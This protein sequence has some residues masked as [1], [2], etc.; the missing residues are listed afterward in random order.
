ML[1]ITA[2][3]FMVLFSVAYSSNSADDELL[4]KVYCCVLN[5]LEADGK[6]TVLS[7]PEPRKLTSCKNIQETEPSST[8]GFYESITSSGEVVNLYCN[9]DTLCGGSGWTRVAYLDMSNSSHE[10]PSTMKENNL[11]VRN[12]R[13]G[14]TYGCDSVKIPTYDIQYSE[15]CGRVSGYQ[16]GSTNGFGYRDNRFKNI[17]SAYLDGVSITRGSPRQHVW[18]YVAGLNQ[19]GR[20][21]YPAH[22]CPKPDGT[23]GTEPS[24]SFVGNDFYCESGNSEPGT[25]RNGVPYVSDMLWDGKDCYPD[26]EV[27]C[28]DK[29]QGVSQPWFYKKFTSST[30]DD[31]ELRSCCNDEYQLD[32]EDI[33]LVSYELYIR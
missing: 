13:R 21:I 24:P 28:R 12:C 16:Y 3:T 31:L 7:K 9:M 25:F 26:E 27:A 33:L 1:T 15:I 32:T 6:T 17:N 18:T 19:N 2:V 20:G 30:T 14:I 11:G 10:C 22:Q 29:I 8:T 4:S 23:Y 5:I